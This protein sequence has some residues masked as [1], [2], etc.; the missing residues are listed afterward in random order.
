MVLGGCSPLDVS[1]ERDV[2]A[3]GGLPAAAESLPSAPREPG[4]ARTPHPTLLRGRGDAT[5]AR[6]RRAGDVA[7]MCA[8][9]AEALPGFHPQSPRPPALKNTGNLS[10]LFF[11]FTSIPLIYN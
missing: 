2:C 6:V 1:R 4:P 8:D 5:A 11:Q 10:L 3:E 9:P 7:G